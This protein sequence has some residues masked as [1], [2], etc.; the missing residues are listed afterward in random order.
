[1]SIYLSSGVANIHLQSFLNDSTTSYQKTMERLSSGCKFTTVGDDPLGVSKTARIESR[2]SANATAKS[3]VELGADLLTIAEDNQDLVISD[4]QRIRDLCEQAANGTYTSS[5][6]DDILDEIKQRLSNIDN[7]ADSTK[8]NRISLLDGSSSNLT[9]QIGATATDTMDIGSALINVHVSQLGL[10]TNKDLR[11]DDTV[12]G[13]SWTHADIGAYM[14]KIDSA[15]NQ[16]TGTEAQIGG[17]ITRLDAKTVT[18][19]S[20][21]TN[22]TENKSIISDTDIAEASADLIK[23]QILQESTASILIQANQVP[24]MAMQLLE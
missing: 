12:T 24:S 1:M 8:F 19:T 6:K 17:Y 21:N 5:D 11:L 18:L 10:D 13:A 2:I 9:L 20:M 4:L 22:L 14:D 15:I 3:N 16:L 7:I 23:Y